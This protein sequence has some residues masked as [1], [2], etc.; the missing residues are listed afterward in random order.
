MRGLALIDL[1]TVLI[2]IGG[3]CHLLSA[4]LVDLP[5]GSNC[6]PLNSE[7]LPEFQLADGTGVD[8]WVD[9]NV[10][11]VGTIANLSAVPHYHGSQNGRQNFNPTT[12]VFGMLRTIQPTLHPA[13][14]PPESIS[15]P[16]AR[17][18]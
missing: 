4:F 10:S 13:I 15:R 3:E 17:Q 9:D 14:D 12:S 18:V 16:A 6:L 7:H 11:A 5:F 8:K 2:E 1:G